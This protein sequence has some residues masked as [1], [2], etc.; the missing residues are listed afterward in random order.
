MEM[1]AARLGYREAWFATLAR[2]TLEWVLAT[3][4]EPPPAALGAA[5]RCSI[6]EDRP[7]PACPI[8]VPTDADKVVWN[9]AVTLRALSCSLGPWGATG[10]VVINY[11]LD[12]LTVQL[13]NTGMKP[14]HFGM[15]PDIVSMLA[16]L[17]IFT[18][19]KSKHLPLIHLLS[20]ALPQRCQYRNFRDICLSYCRDHECVRE[21]VRS[22]IFFTLAGLYPNQETKTPQ[23]N[24]PAFVSIETRFELYF[25]FL[26]MST[27]E[28]F[29]W[30][31]QYHMIAFYAM[32]DVILRTLPY[33]D[34]LYSTIMLYY[35]WDGFNASTTQAL[36]K[37]A[38]LWGAPS[39]NQREKLNAELVGHHTK[40]VRSLF[41]LVPT[42][43]ILAIK[44]SVDR[45][46]GTLFDGSSA[47]S[48]AAFWCALVQ[49]SEHEPPRDCLLNTSTF[50]EILDRLDLER[51]SVSAIA[52]SVDFANAGGQWR[53]QFERMLYSLSPSSQ[54]IVCSTLFR[55][56]VLDEVKVFLLPRHVLHSQYHALCRRN[57]TPVTATNH[58]E[59]T[60][61][62]FI[63]MTCNAFKGFLVDNSK[64]N[65]GAI[66]HEKVCF[67]D[68]TGEHYCTKSNAS[69]AS[70]NG[71]N[72]RR[73]M[74]ASL[75][76]SIGI[77]TLDGCRS[78]PLVRVTLLGSALSF[79]GKVTVLCMR[80]GS[81]TLF[82][83]HL[84]DDDICCGFCGEEAPLAK[85]DYCLG[86]CSAFRQQHRTIYI[87]TS[88]Y[89]PVLS[90]GS[91][92][93]RHPP[94]RG[95]RKIWVKSMLLKQLKDN[96]ERRIM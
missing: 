33:D 89:P 65:V 86:P 42:V 7:M 11:A 55:L 45:T 54:A 25:D 70:Q 40:Q 66:G 50:L 3:N 23:Y 13:G 72:P 2:S 35:D 16:K 62:F 30:M 32:K 92:C 64:M 68:A 80:C 43:P 76:S 24:R 63:C 57:D 21:F 83:L 27:T 17:N 19:M 61:R 26:T 74:R 46:I 96:A 84:L 6:F 58:V 8:P 10:D 93:C 87:D 41:K 9:K 60:A 44:N 90:H 14:R 85:C 81:P 1:F 67:D 69:A 95:N 39:K 91:L 51:E 4:A 59:H 34:A 36:Q 53:P 75:L 18:E 38:E 28:F 22:A 48:L 79:C 77:G 71:R 12:S 78:T 49:T 94:P 15:L 47:P 20:K 37:T 56:S 52:K 29:A 88:V 73:K 5:I 31:R 82:R